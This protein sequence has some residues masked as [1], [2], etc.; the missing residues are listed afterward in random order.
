MGI[1]IA[2]KNADQIEETLSRLGYTGAISGKSNTAVGLEDSLPDTIDSDVL[3]AD[4]TV[5]K[6]GS[7]P[8]ALLVIKRAHPTTKIYFLIGS[9]NRDL[10]KNQKIF[11][12]M[13]K[14]GI[15]VVSGVLSTGQWRAIA[16]INE[17]KPEPTVITAPSEEKPQAQDD[18]IT[19]NLFMISSPK[20]GSGKSFVSSNLA[21]MLALYGKRREGKRPSVLLLDG[22]LQNLSVTNLLGISDDVYNLKNV[23]E[24]ISNIVSDDGVVTGTPQQQE[25]IFDIIAK[26]CLQVSDRCDNLFAMVSPTFPLA[27]REKVS[28]YHYYYLVQILTDMFDIVL[29][30]SNSSTEHKT[31]GPTMQVAREIFMVVTADYEGVRVAQKAMDDLATLRVE[32]KTAFVLNKCITKAQRAHSTEKTVFNPDKY[33]QN[34]RI[35]ARIPYVDQVLQY[36]RLYEKKPLVLDKTPDTLLARIAFTRLAKNIWPMDNMSDLEA[37][38]QALKTQNK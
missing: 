19:N 18:P 3:I 36:N 12:V 27:D 2:S 15:N 13:E 25:E 8:R 28:P 30:D 6:A 29:V 31:T 4:L 35:A 11:A 21:Y 34:R 37:E 38:V 22:D 20:A 24:A 16:G 5:E 9:L 23:L 17:I 32:D 1:Y 10:P 33:L 7:M 26:S 14:E